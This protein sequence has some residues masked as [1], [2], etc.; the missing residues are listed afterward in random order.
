M[1][2]DVKSRGNIDFHF[3]PIWKRLNFVKDVASKRGVFVRIYRIEVGN[4]ILSF[5]K[6][7][8]GDIGVALTG[9]SN[10]SRCMKSFNKRRHEPFVNKLGI[11]KFTK[12]RH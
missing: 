1:K 6:D 3:C 10:F 12:V 8:K 9:T 7:G 4:L 5:R 11:Q 2:R